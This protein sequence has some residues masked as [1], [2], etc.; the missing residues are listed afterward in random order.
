MKDKH[1]I[2][3]GGAPTTGKSTV[4][5]AL[6]KELNLPWLSTDQIRDTMRVVADE[7]R[8]PNLFNGGLDAET[9]LTS[10]TASEIVDKEIA[11][12]EA[13]WLGIKAFIEKDYTW[14]KGFIIE[15]VNILPHLVARDFSGN[16]N[17]RAV[18]LIDRDNER[19]RKV[20]YERGLWADA[21]D[22]PDYVKEKEMEWATLF[23]E[24]LAAATKRHGFSLIEIHKTGND[25]QQVM[26]ALNGY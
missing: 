2:L 7:D 23:G 5:Q 3:I 11:Q 18:F 10:F 16:P 9:F 4:A 21:G 12:S 14:P 19:M 24:R 17:V 8:H 15:G 6:A 25:M 1:I 22:Y 13:A 26:S 20:I